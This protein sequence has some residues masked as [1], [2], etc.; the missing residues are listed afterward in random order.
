MAFILLYNPLYN[1]PWLIN[2]IGTSEV[3]FTF[4]WSFTVVV[5]AS[6][7]VLDSFAVTR[8]KNFPFEE[9]RFQLEPS[10]GCSAKQLLSTGR[11]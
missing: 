2:H 1:P 3:D 9:Q 10:H 4:F 5:A 11:R 8:G 7:L 6:A